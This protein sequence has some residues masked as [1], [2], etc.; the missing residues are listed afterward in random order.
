MIAALGFVH[1]MR[2]DE[3]RHA[4]TR[5]VEKQI[6]QLATRHRVD[7]GSRLV[8]KKHGRFV[9]ERTRHGQALAHSAGKQRGAHLDERLE[10]RDCDHFVTTLI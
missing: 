9:H 3:K 8:E 5:E 1:V 4:F 6:P 2:R 10:M 7:A